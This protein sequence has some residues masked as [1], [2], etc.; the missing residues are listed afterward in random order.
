MEQKIPI[1]NELIMDLKVYSHVYIMSDNALKTFPPIKLSYEPLLHKKVYNLFIAIPTGKKYFI[2]F[3]YDTTNTCYLVEVNT[4]TKQPVRAEKITVIYDKLLCGTVLYGT[5]IQYKNV[6]YFATENIHYYSGKNIEDIPYF[7]KLNIFKEIFETKLSMKIYCKNDVSIGLCYM[8]NDKNEML[9]Q[10]DYL[11]YNVYGILQRMNSNNSSYMMPLMKKD[12]EQRVIFTICA[13]VINDIYH[14]YYHNFD[15]GLTFHQSAY[16]PDY[17]TS[18][19]MNNYFR[20]IKENQ[21]LDSL[22]ESDDEDE[23]ENIEEDK[24]V[25]LDRKMNFECIYNKRF[26]KW[27]PI[28]RTHEKRIINAKEL[29]YI[30]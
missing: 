26:K 12:N 16:I 21:N 17:K 30:K 6:K 19:M 2:W 29:K 27:V 8:T 14:L 28:K 1:H 22:E 25:Y 18:V 7:K 3:T 24:Y 11:Y 10:I 9:K 15:K 20:I 4:K 13:D 5:L 23:F